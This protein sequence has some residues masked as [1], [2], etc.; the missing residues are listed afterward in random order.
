MTLTNKATFIFDM[1]GT[2]IDA[3]QLNI[4][5][6]AETIKNYFGIEISKE[7]YNI[8][9]SGVK[10][11]KAFEG[12]LESKNIYKYNTNELIE[13][14][15]NIKRNKLINEPEK[16][17]VIFPHLKDFL[18]KLKENSKK[19]VLATS[20]I[21]EFTHLILKHFDIE[22]YFTHIL[23]AE[24]VKEGKPN[25]EIYLKALEISDSEINDAVVF[26]DSKSGIEAALNAGIYC[27]AIHT[28][29]LNDE[30]IE[31]ANSSIESYSEIMV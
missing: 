23:T 3:E 25:P 10:T 8:Y 31:T 9:F 28:K 19:V 2:I 26:E 18:I 6:Y 20:T 29:G 27:V 22:K 1:D 7:E 15:R 17:L 14:F 4:S 11:A 5:A 24:D 13:Y 16:V 30:F 12:Y 21:S